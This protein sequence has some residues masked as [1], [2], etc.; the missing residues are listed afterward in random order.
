MW[1]APEAKDIAGTSKIGDKPINLETGV[2]NR[3]L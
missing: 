3:T 1:T 2:V